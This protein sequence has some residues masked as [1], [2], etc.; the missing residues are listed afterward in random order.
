MSNNINYNSISS[1][2]RHYPIAIPPDPLQR[3]GSGHLDQDILGISVYRSNSIQ[4]QSELKLCSYPSDGHLRL[5][6]STD[7]NIHTLFDR[8]MAAIQPVFPPIRV[9]KNNTPLSVHLAHH[10]SDIK[11]SFKVALQGRHLSHHND[12]IWTI[13]FTFVYI[14][15]KISISWSLPIVRYASARC[16][17]ER[18]TTWIL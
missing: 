8:H 6:H 5:V 16:T 18:F 7:P 12:H 9:Y 3:Y 14:S 15:E 4:Q 1:S 11:F 13:V 10:D 2:N 17:F